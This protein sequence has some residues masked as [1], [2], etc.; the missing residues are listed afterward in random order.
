MLP[1]EVLARRDKPLFTEVF[2]GRHSRALATG[3]DGA[4]LNERLV[5]PEALKEAWRQPVPD[6]R[7]ALILQSL[8]LDGTG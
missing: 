6:S 1:E 2:W 8:W 7:T 3:W 5:D 4:G